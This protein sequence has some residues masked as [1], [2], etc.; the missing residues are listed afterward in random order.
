MPVTRYVDFDGTLAYYDEWH[1]PFHLGEPV[2][3]MVNKVKAWLTLGD[4]VVIFC[5]RI[6]RSPNFVK[7][8]E[9]KK[10][11]ELIEEWCVKH[12]GQKLPVTGVKGEFKFCYDDR[13]V[14]IIKNA[15]RSFEEALLNYI[16][17][18]EDL[19]EDL[20]DLED[21]ISDVIL[22]YVKSRL[23]QRIKEFS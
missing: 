3:L 22:S 21:N 7:Q 12:I 18:L 1:G 14:G 13:A 15:G 11:I 9:V 2:L 16:E 8:E 4:K 10:I 23:K 17:D 5:A 20:E 6:G 19:T